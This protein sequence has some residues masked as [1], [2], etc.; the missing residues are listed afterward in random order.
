MDTTGQVIR[1]PEWL[2]TAAATAG[3]NRRHRRLLP[4]T[5][6]RLHWQTLRSELVVMN[7]LTTA[8]TPPGSYRAST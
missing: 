5:R 2:T 8:Y 4:H 6:D 3:M 7:R 1:P